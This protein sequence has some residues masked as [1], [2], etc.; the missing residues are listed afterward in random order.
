[1]AKVKNTKFEDMIWALD[2]KA[3]IMIYV[4]EHQTSDK[5]CNVYELFSDSDYMRK[6]GGDKVAEISV[7]F[8]TI[9]VLLEK[10]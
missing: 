7:T 2:A 8:G 4:D 6:H 5:T 10:A 1:M 9:M 3:R